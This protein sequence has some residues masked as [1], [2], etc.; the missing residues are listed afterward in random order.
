[1]KRITK[2]FLEQAGIM[3]R[4]EAVYDIIGVN[5]V[6]F[7]LL[8]IKNRKGWLQLTALWTDLLS[9]PYVQERILNIRKTQPDYTPNLV[10]F[11]NFLSHTS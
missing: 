7:S 6:D 9:Q 8:T 3:E 2:Y 11:E 4:A 10:E 1:M 5:P